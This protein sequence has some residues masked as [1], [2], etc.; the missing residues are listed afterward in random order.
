MTVAEGVD[1][2]GEDL[3]DAITHAAEMFADGIRL[4]FLVGGLG[5]GIGVAIAVVGGAIKFGEAVVKIDVFVANKEDG[6]ADEGKGSGDESKHKSD[7]KTKGLEI[8]IWG[9]G[10]G[11][12]GGG[13]RLLGHGVCPCYSWSG[14]YVYI[15][16]NRGKMSRGL[17]G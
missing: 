11:G 4:I 7:A 9:F 3:F 5:E 16:A 8:G 14:V 6:R 12:L 2:F 10:V 17:M 1:K 15:N 13:R